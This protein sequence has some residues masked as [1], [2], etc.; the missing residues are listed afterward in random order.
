MNIFEKV[1]KCEKIEK[2]RDIL[3]KENESLKKILRESDKKT[4]KRIAELKTELDNCR[5]AR[6]DD[7]KR[8]DEEIEKLKRERD[9]L[10]RHFKLGSE[11]SQDVITAVRTDKRV[12]ELELENI[13]LK[14][15]MNYMSD[16]YDIYLKSVKNLQLAGLTQQRSIY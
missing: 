7:C 5:K 8:K 13:E 11:P 12:H 6:L 2:Q 14:T 3:R 1:K 16:L 15:R 4:T 10:Y 9:M